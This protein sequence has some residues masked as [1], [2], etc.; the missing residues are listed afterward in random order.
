[1][2]DTVWATKQNDLPAVEGRLENRILSNIE[3]KTSVYRIVKHLIPFGFQPWDAIL[4]MVRRDLLQR[5]N[6]RRKER[7]W[8][9][10]EVTLSEG[11]ERYEKEGLGVKERIEDFKARESEL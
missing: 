8:L 4:N 3:D 11:M 6:R 2:R 5:G 9:P 7:R 1:M 10:T